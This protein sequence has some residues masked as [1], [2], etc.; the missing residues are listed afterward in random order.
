MK[1]PDVIV[2]TLAR[3]MMAS[4]LGVTFSPDA[5][6]ALSDVALTLPQSVAVTVTAI[7]SIQAAPETTRQPSAIVV[8]LDQEWDHR[9]EREFRRLALKEAT[10][11]LAQSDAR[12]LD[13]LTRLRNRL[14][15]PQTPDEM[16]LQIRRDRLLNKTKE[17]LNEYVQFKHATDQSRSAS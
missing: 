12:R 2:R 17:L 1:K 6:N 5:Y 16:L 10:G 4:T 14:L 11:A 3:G 7:P 13:E 15:C 8:R 9:M